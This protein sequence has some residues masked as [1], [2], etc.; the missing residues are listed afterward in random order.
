MMKSLCESLR[1]QADL[2]L[3]QVANRLPT[4]CEQ[5]P[6]LLKVALSRVHDYRF[7]KEEPVI[8]RQSPIQSI[9]EATLGVKHLPWGLSL[10]SRQ[11]PAS[12]QDR[13]LCPED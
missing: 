11:W 1:E 6:V 3:G 8:T 10:G 9:K 12:G 13:F 2:S 4:K 7:S 5:M